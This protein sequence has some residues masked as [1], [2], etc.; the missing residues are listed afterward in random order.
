M[1][2][3]TYPTNL[4]YSL[5]TPKKDKFLRFFENLYNLLNESFHISELIAMEKIG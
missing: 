2:E 3:S 4:R 5:I 1:T